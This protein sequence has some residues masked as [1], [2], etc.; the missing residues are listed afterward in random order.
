MATPASLFPQAAGKVHE[1][2]TTWKHLRKNQ[3][4]N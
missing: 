3:D 4:V 2:R 1:S